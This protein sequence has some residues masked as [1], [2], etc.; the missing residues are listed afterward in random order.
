[1]IE[2][3]KLVQS[4]RVSAL[5]AFITKAKK[6]NISRQIRA[7]NQALTQSVVPFIIIV[8]APAAAQM[9]EYHGY[10]TEDDEG[11]RKDRSLMEG[12]DQLIALELPNLVGDGLHLEERITVRTVITKRCSVNRRKPEHKEI[13]K[14]S[15]EATRKKNVIN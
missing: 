14:L 7:H 8:L 4:Q 5:R 15:S 1:M 13:I 6:C 2:N 11:R 10:M 9:L 3:V 12:H